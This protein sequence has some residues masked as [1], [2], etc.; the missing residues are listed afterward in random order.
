M[1]DSILGGAGGGA[2]KGASLGAQAGTMIMPG[3]GTAI[4]AVG[5]AVIGGVAGGMK[6]KKAQDTRDKAQGFMPGTQDPTQVQRLAEIDQIAKNI[7]A[8]TDSATQTGLGQI[9]GQTAQTQNRLARVT[10][11]NIGATV[12]ALLKAQRAGGDASNQAIAQ[13]QQRLPF[14]KGLGQDLANRIEQ[15]SLDINLLNRDQYMAEAAQAQ[16]ENVINRNAAVASGL[17]VNELGAAANELLGH[18]GRIKSLLS[19]L[20][21]NQ[22]YK[23]NAD[24]NGTGMAIDPQFANPLPNDMSGGGFTGMEVPTQNIGAFA[25][26]F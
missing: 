15:R 13:G 11:G 6:S 4:G 23:Q 7:Q 19:N 2:A 8:G 26:M 16:K 21:L 9:Q 22:S 10:G 14:F 24:M 3:I 17:G 12:D 20:K 5:G 25:G 1:A 18:E